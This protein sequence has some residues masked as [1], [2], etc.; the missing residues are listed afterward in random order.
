MKEDTCPAG[1]RLPLFRSLT[2]Q[3]L[4]LGAPRGFMVMNLMMLAI[5]VVSFHFFYIVPLHVI[6]HF[7]AIYLA[8][9]DA[10]FFE[11]LKLYLR[12]KDYYCT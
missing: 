10:Q 8:K 2:E 6:L 4:V 5:F 11:C 9:H 1:F 7:G 12:K 3:V